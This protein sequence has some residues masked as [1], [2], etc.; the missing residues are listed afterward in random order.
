MSLPIYNKISKD[1]VIVVVRFSNSYQDLQL[2][3]IPL[4]SLTTSLLRQSVRSSISDL[5]RKRIRFIHSG[6]VLNEKTDFTEEYN[7]FLKF[8]KQSSTEEGTNG[9]NNGKFY[10]HCLIGDEMTADELSKENELDNKV[11]AKSTTEAPIGFDRLSSAGFSQEDINNLRQQF[12][13]LYGDL[14]SRRGNS[15]GEEGQDIRQLEERWIDSTVNEMDEFSQTNL[16]VGGNNEDLFIGLLIGCLLGVLSLFLLKYDNL[17]SKRQ[18]MAI[19]AGFI[20][21]F[22]FALVRQWN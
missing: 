9:N 3:I 7:Q 8:Q 6:K 5:Q 22:T 15:D 10:I 21:N 17:F 1:N 16:S 20:I 12:R 4:K 14:P 11:F 2:P 19:I 13:Q 18:K